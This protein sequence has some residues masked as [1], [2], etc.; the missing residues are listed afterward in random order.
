MASYDIEGLDLD[1]EGDGW[2]A[3][4]TEDLLVRLTEYDGEKGSEYVVSVYDDYALN[5]EGR[6]TPNRF[7][8]YDYEGGSDDKKLK[9]VR[10]YDISTY[11]SEGNWE[12][13]RAD[14]L[15]GGRISSSISL[16]AKI[17]SIC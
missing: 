2:K 13:I 12:G 5:D 4:L 17:F 11:Y 10:S 3:E 9:E 6:N 7:S 8:A 15:N 14:L 16:T 1:F